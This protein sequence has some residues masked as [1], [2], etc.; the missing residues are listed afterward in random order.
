MRVISF[1]TRLSG[2]KTSFEAKDLIQC[3]RLMWFLLRSYQFC[4]SPWSPSGFEHVLEQ[5]SRALKIMEITLYLRRD[6]SRWGVLMNN[7][8]PF[9]NGNTIR[10]HKVKLYAWAGWG[11]SGRI[12]GWDGCNRIALSH[13]NTQCLLHGWQSEAAIFTA[14]LVSFGVRRCFKAFLTASVGKIKHAHAKTCAK[15][16]FSWLKGC[17]FDLSL[18]IFLYHTT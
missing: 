11:C 2:R 12:W 6:G 10:P 4:L 14:G 1:K 13:T 15:R 16:T 17:K 9:G 8:S 5:W 7:C 18:C 3:K